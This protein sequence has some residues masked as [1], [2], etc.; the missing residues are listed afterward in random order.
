MQ[1]DTRHGRYEAKNTSECYA[2]YDDYWAVQGN[3]VIFV[4]NDTIQ[5][6]DNSLLLYVS[7][8]PRWDSWAKNMWAS[9]NGTGK[10]T[11]VSPP[12]P[13]TTWF[14]GPPRYEVAS[15]LVQVPQATSNR[16]RLQYSTHISY[17]VVV[18]N[19]VKFLALFL[20]WQNRKIED[21]RRKARREEE[22]GD[23]PG[24][25]TTPRENT[26]STLGDAIASFMREPD[27]TTKNMCLATKYDIIN[28]EKA[29]TLKRKGKRE[30]ILEPHPREWKKEKMRWMSA[31]TWK[32]WLHLIL[33]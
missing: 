3:A 2:L 1:N 5:G 9:S 7:V 10:F 20:I 4:K 18:L 32:Q 15:C 25:I 12:P 28:K 6:V 26:L 30:P 17:T 23:E 8:T 14:L 27:E 31:A 16:C 22:F 11:A 21:R 13:V 24:H 33:M 29:A 19:F